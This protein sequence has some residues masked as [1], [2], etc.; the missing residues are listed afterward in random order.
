MSSTAIGVHSLLLWQSVIQTSYDRNTLACACGRLKAMNCLSRRLLRRCIIVALWGLFRWLAYSMVVARPCYVYNIIIHRYRLYPFTT[1]DNTSI[2][3]WN[4]GSSSHH[5]SCSWRWLSNHLLI[6]QIIG[7][8]LN[9]WKT[10]MWKVVES[11]LVD[12][13][14]EYIVVLNFKL[15]L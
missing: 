4:Y 15:D 3:I 2:A 12:V 10:L 7:G 13:L 1:L 14:N 5:T 9:I 8:S 6:K 11:H